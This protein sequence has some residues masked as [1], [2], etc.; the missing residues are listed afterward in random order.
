MLEALSNKTFLMTSHK[1][2]Q[3]GSLIE[4]REG[5]SFLTSLHFDHTKLGEVYPVYDVDKIRTMTVVHEKNWL[6]HLPTPT[7]RGLA[8]QILLRKGPRRVR[9]SRKELGEFSLYQSP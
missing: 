4:T 1:V 7:W 6:T 9:L 5:G 3:Y 2:T 8:R